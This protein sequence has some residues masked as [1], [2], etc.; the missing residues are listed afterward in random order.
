MEQQEYLRRQTLVSKAFRPGGPIDDDALFAGRRTQMIRVIDTIEQPGQHAAI[1]GG[2]GV[3]KTSLAKVMVKALGGGRLAFHYTSS[4]TDT[5]DSTWRAVL[6]DLQLTTVVATVGFGSQDREIV[7]AASDLLPDDEIRA[8]D[9]RRALIVLVRAR[10]FVLFVDEF[11]RPTDSEIKAKFAD[12]IKILSDQLVPA[13]L[14][15]VGV[16]DDVDGLIAEHESIRRSLAEIYMPN[17][18]D[19]ELAEIISKGMTA[20][21]MGVDDAFT[22]AVVAIAQGLPSYVHL[23]AQNA[24]RVALDADR[25]D[26]LYQDIDSAITRSVES[27][28]QAVLDTYHRA[29][30]SNRETLYKE[31]LL[32]CALAP[33]DEK[34]LFS[35]SDVRTELEKITGTFR[36]LP[37]FAQHMNDFSGNGRR[38]GVLEKIGESYR[39]KYR[40]RDPLLQPYVLMRGRIDG[41]M[42]GSPKRPPEPDP[43]P[44]PLPGIGD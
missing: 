19:T 24:A 27:I 23:I 38:G 44:E 43:K 10:P 20:A 21:E 29:T 42:P 34:G 8:D 15:L 26:V 37:A 9:V 18:S 13:T 16:A 14:V 3:G 33:R 17:M 12:L 40:F 22:P 36:D 5:F 11:E 4:T 1:Y 31:V 28:Q 2:R 6:A 25:T 7:Q 32:A 30:R 39:Y 41:L 35:S